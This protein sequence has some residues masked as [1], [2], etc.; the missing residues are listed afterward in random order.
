MEPFLFDSDNFHENIILVY[1]SAF[2]SLCKLLA[3]IA[4]QKNNEVTVK[5]EEPIHAMKKRA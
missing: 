4:G 5:K 2:N 1:K 3:R